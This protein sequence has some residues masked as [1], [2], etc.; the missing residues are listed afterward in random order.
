MRFCEV[1]LARK[2]WGRR[3][4]WPHWNRPL[5]RCRHARSASSMQQSGPSLLQTIP[6]I[7]YRRKTRPRPGCWRRWTNQTVAH[8][9]NTRSW[10]N[11]W[12][13]RFARSSRIYNHHNHNSCSY[14]RRNAFATGVPY[15][16]KSALKVRLVVTTNELDFQCIFTIL[17]TAK[18]TVL[19][20]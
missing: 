17:R 10:G 16:E 20:T 4:G 6:T 19:R 8:P 13:W 14:T 12:R 9:P 1:H 5:A 15:D 18:T 11:H 3:E 2:R 7:E